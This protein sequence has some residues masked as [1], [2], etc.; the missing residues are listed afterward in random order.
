[1]T[2]NYVVFILKILVDTKDSDCNTRGGF[3]NVRGEKINR[4]HR[5]SFIQ[6]LRL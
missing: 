3:Y 2:T 1:M 5:D 4:L 6:T